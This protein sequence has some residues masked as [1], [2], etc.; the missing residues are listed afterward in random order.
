MR[1]RSSVMKSQTLEQRSAARSKFMLRVR[2]RSA[3]GGEHCEALREVDVVDVS[4]DVVL[5]GFERAIRSQLE[6]HHPCE[7]RCEGGVQRERGFCKHFFNDT[8]TAEI[9]TRSDSDALPI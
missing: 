6:L 3:A 5:S 4:L 1:A 2:R 7:P 8:A 9:Y